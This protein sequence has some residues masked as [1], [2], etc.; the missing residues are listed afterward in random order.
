MVMSELF[1]RFLR[2]APACVMHRALLENVFAAESLDELFRQRAQTQ[3]ERELLFSTLVELVGQV[4][5]RISKS[6]HAA[7]VR[8]RE[9]ISVS[10]R[11]L[12]DKLAHVEPATSRA[13][14]QY[15]ARR[16][17]DLIDRTQGQRKPLLA[18]YR[19]RILDGNHL[20]KTQHRL[21]VLRN[22][23]AGALPGQALVLLDPQRMVIDDV[24]PCEDG[25]TQE[26][27]LLGQVLPCIER[28]DLVIDDRNFCTLGFLFGLKRR[29][30]YFITR[31]HGRMPWTALSKPQYQGRC[32][33]GRVYEQAIE[34]CDPASGQTTQLRRITLRL[35][36]PTGD[37]DGE[38]HLHT[39]LP[40]QVSARKIAELYRQRWT[41][42]QAFQE[43][44]MHLRCELNTLGYPKAALFAFCVAVCSYNLLA[45]V[46]GALRG[47]HGEAVLEGEVSNYFL[48]DE[49]NTHYAGMMVALPPPEWTEFQTMPA[50]R[51]A[52]HLSRWARQVDL[53]NYPKHPRAAKKPKPKPP[54]AQFQHVATARLLKA[55][56]PKPP[57]PK[58]KSDTSG[59]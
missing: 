18:G 20:G 30:A 19:V 17:N 57:R 24:V 50:T 27:A 47:V 4:V 25:H 56:P 9:R 34:L 5:C 58:R 55:P 38:I 53:T 29:K 54:N 39:N 46:K 12:Y 10:L 36:V 59:P 11:A 13:L 43:L 51:F 23:S 40:P 33:T 15:T 52:A 49:I 8:Q 37:G 48:T 1:E 22:T 3:Y 7:Y 41:V 31:E 42:E 6:V 2:S 28:R 44:T 16:V 32:E 14:V 26:R 21:K 45:A 35:D